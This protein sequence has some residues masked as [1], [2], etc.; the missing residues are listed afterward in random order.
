VVN[1]ARFEDVD[2]S[3]AVQIDKLLRGAN[4][5]DIP[6]EQPTKFVL[7]VNTNRAQALGL[8]VPPDVAT[9]VTDWV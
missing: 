4:P 7:A 8:T 2:L 9:L 5:A 6:V 3:L 1:A